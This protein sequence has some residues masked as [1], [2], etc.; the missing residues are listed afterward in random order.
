MN[1]DTLTSRLDFSKPIS[2]S[3]LVSLLRTALQAGEFRFVRQ[4]ALA[5]L[6]TFPG[7]LGVSYLLAKG[8]AAE[9]KISQTLPILEKLCLLD[10]EFGEA[11]DLL[12]TLQPQEK[13]PTGRV[14]AFLRGGR[15]PGAKLG[16]AKGADQAVM[17]SESVL[18]TVEKQAQQAMI[19]DPD[20]VL[21]ALLQLQVLWARQDRPAIQNLA[22]QYHQRWPECLQ[23]TLLLAENRL[24]NGDETGAVALLHQC[25]AH[26]TAGQ[27]PARIWGE[28]NPYRPLWPDRMEM[29]FDIAI[30]GAVAAAMGW[31]Q[32]PSGDSFEQSDVVSE[33][34]EGQTENLPN[35][36]SSASRPEALP[37]QDGLVLD[38]ETGVSSTAP[39]ETLRSVQEEFEKLA[40]RLKRPSVGRTDGRFP[41]YV[42]L[43]TRAGLEKQ[44][45]AQTAT[46]IDGELRKMVEAVRR[47]PGW[48]SLVFYPDDPSSTAIYGLKPV[49]AND[50]WKVK[51]AIADLDQALSKRGEMIGA[52]FIIGGPEIVPFHRLPNPTDDGDSEVL[53]DNPYATTD[54]NYFVPE[55]PVGRLPGETGP[56]AGMLLA[57]LRKLVEH[58]SQAFLPSPWWRRLPPLSW[59]FKR[60]N[61]GVAYAGKKVRSSVGFTA[62]V[63]QRSSS[64]VF[65]V[66]G[67]PQAMLACPPVTSGS[68]TWNGKYLPAKLG[69][70]NLHGLKDGPEWYGQKDLDDPAGAPD[71][72]VAIGPK[73][74][75]DSAH[76]PKIIFSEA[77]YGS[78]IEAKRMSEALSLHFLAS[79]TAAMVGSTCIAYGAVAA[80]LTAADLLGQYFWERLRE[81]QSVGNALRQA[82]IAL[83][84][85]MT[86]RQG[87]LD[88]ED[89]KTLL[90]FIL[91]GD[92]LV[93]LDDV[94]VESKTIFR[95]KVRHMLKTVSDQQE[96]SQPEEIPAEV[97]K[98]VKQVVDQYLPGLR[99]AELT[100]IQQNVPVS[101]IPAAAKG[102]KSKTTA[103]SDGSRIQVTLSKQVKTAQQVHQH[104]A[105]IT[106]DSQGHVLKLSASR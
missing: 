103:S 87:Y 11:Q 7:D 1:P 2:R 70:F 51:L 78:N 52:L 72:P 89:Q 104:Y 56:D 60:R 40:K 79:G 9:E 17:R 19:D 35:T 80:P 101:N 21:P 8:M 48:G 36:G 5:W 53:S 96:A 20:S 82:K 50:P 105:R 83:A 77:C 88:G 30:P 39:S 75:K 67:Q 41:M 44:Y 55:W 86:K 28:Q 98:Q 15:L 64:E 93:T 4:A 54:E 27:V 84:R 76:A 6:A 29:Y 63:W 94:R 97:L 10:P 32:L 65:K 62:K 43:S 58:H 42:I 49:P 46:I 16:W 26:D 85:D 47:R 71:Y 91:Y 100:M 73:D 33:P 34:T 14:K 12:K 95:P 81:G 37:A 22:E 68:N 99:D 24:T 106:L 66:I 31:N 18:Q 23:F 57:L 3:A 38:S 59:L 92:P 74:V 45:G 61:I 90:S 69:Y 102:G 13:A 25:A